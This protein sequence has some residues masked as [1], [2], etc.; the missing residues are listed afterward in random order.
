M[1]RI[2]G[3]LKVVGKNYYFYATLYCVGIIGMLIITY[4]RYDILAEALNIDNWEEVMFLLGTLLSLPIL[5]LMFLKKITRT[6][7]ITV[8][9]IMSMIVMVAY[10]ISTSGAETFVTRLKTILAPVLAAFFIY[11]AVTSIIYVW[12]KVKSR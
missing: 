7:A 11:S 6:L 9:G 4:F 1:G 8:A 5:C 12:Q 2:V 10:W 3:K